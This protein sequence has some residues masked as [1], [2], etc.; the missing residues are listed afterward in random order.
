MSSPSDDKTKQDE[1][2][3]R[4]ACG[5]LGLLFGAVAAMQIHGSISSI[6]GW[7]TLL[8][9]LNFGSYAFTYKRSGD[10]VV[11][12]SKRRIWVILTIC[13]VPPLILLF[14]FGDRPGWELW[15]VTFFLLSISLGPVLLL[16]RLAD[17]PSKQD[18]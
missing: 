11:R 4:G 2:A 18:Q 5:A 16:R 17:K 1:I 6:G 14:F 10:T 8:I 12:A 3:V 9:A 13:V 15:L 7:T